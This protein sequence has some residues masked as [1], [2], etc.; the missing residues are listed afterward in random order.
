MRALERVVQVHRSFAKSTYSGPLSKK[1]SAAPTASRL[2]AAARPLLR[3]TGVLLERWCRGSTHSRS[4]ETSHR[5]LFKRRR[6]TLNRYPA[7]VR[8]HVVGVRYHRRAASAAV[9][10]VSRCHR[11][12]A[13]AAV[14]FVVSLSLSASCVSCRRIRNT[15]IGIRVGAASYHDH[16]RAHV[17]RAAAD[18][19][20]SRGVTLV[21]P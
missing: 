8:S 1:Q 9:T 13:S 18:T 6:P 3:F 21:E 12:A 7:H 16:A 2:A 4:L 17:A 15:I 19:A 5:S 11:R 20:T 10:S 14:V